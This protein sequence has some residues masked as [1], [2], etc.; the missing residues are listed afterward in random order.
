MRNKNLICLGAVAL[1]PF[2]ID[3]AAAVIP[4]GNVNLLNWREALGQRQAV[5]QGLDDAAVSSFFNGNVNRAVLP[6]FHLSSFRQQLANL[7]AM[8]AQAQQRQ[9]AAEAEAEQMVGEEE[10]DGAMNHNDANRQHGDGEEGHEEEPAG[11]P[12]PLQHEEGGDA[13]EGEGDGLGGAAG[14]AP[15]DDGGAPEAAQPPVVQAQVPP[16]LHQG[17]GAGNPQPEAAENYHVEQLHDAPAGEEANNIPHQPNHNLP[18]GLL[19][20]EELNPGNIVDQMQLILDLLEQNAHNIQ[21]ITNQDPVQLAAVIGQQMGAERVIAPL[22]NDERDLVANIAGG[23]IV[24]PV[25][26]DDFTKEAFRHACAILDA[27]LAPD[28]DAPEGE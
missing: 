22:T 25:E 6:S 14:D 11:Q 2:V 19:T 18:D 3:G 21:I 26:I 9:A 17:E 4:A 24:V 12:N 28:L 13:E 7:D 5:V 27:A 15:A 8:I 23:R 1:F 10:G 20:A 16:P